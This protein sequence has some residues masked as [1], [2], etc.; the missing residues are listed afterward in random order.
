MSEL[1]IKDWQQG[2]GE[3][4]INSAFSDMRNVDIYSEPGLLKTGFIGAKYSS[5]TVTD[6][7]KWLDVR[8]GANTNL[9]GFGDANKLYT[10]SGISS[11]WSHVSGNTTSAGSGN[12]MKVWKGYV[13]TARNTAM[14][15]YSIGGATWSN[16][17]AGLTL[18]SDALH[19]MIIGQDDILYIGNGRYIASVQEV[20]GSTFDPANSATYVATAQALDLPSS[21]RVR[22]LAE[23]GQYLM[24]GTSQGSAVSDKKVADIFPWD[25]VSSSFDIPLRLNENGILQMINVDNI[26]YIVAGIKHTIYTSNGTS[27]NLLRKLPTSI[28]DFDGGLN[29]CARPGAIAQHRG[30]VITGM[31]TSEASTSGLVTPMGILGITPDGLLTFESQ[32]SIGSTINV[33]IGAI[34]AAGADSY[35]VSW[36][37]ASSTYGIDVIGLDGKHSTA[38]NSFARSALYAVGTKKKPETYSELEIQLATALATGQSV[39]VGYRT[40]ST[41]AFTTL[42]TFDFANY[43][44]VKSF[45]EDI[46]LIDIE[47][48]QIEVQ[49]ASNATANTSPK[50]YYVRL[51]S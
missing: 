4:V 33:S 9:Y 39:V 8:D 11:S 36:R 38:S 13:F 31:A 28:W 50:V 17:W 24:I 15:L 44:A 19:P 22:C 51:F 27:I 42:A 5:T 21:Y 34:L 30:R 46:G 10:A 47:N 29:I 25:R 26:L 40:D 35:A 48:I 49:V 32:V 20:A 16:S 3:S 7:I 18:E 2:I 14:D 45:S 41:S 1:I 37:D 43:G 23:L 12:G 6:F